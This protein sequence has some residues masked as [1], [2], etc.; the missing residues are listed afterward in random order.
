MERHSL[1]RE[2]DPAVRCWQGPAGGGSNGVLSVVGHTPLVPL[3]RLAAEAE[4]RV[5]GKLESL[6][7]GGSI[8][9]RPAAAIIAQGIR[10]GTITADT[11]VVESS[12]GNMGIG[13]AQACR[14]HG[15]RFI[16]VVDVKAMPQNIR[17]LQAYG[18]EIELVAAPD[19]ATGDFLT[20]R[21]GRVQE[22]L[23]RI[24]GAY[25]PNQYAN[26]ENPRSHFRSTMQ[27][28]LSEL[29]GDLD[30]LFVATSTCGTLRGCASF[31]HDHQLPTRLIA[32]DALGSLI[33]SDQ[34][35]H[36]WI[37][38]LGAGMKPPFGDPNLAAEVIHVTDGECVAGCRLLMEREAILAGGSSGGVVA[39]FHRVAPRI[40][41]RATS[42]LVLCDRGERYLD[43]VFDDDWVREHCGTI[44][45]ING[46]Q[47][48]P[49]VPRAAQS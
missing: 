12:S 9:D 7:P 11:V 15:L 35:G 37:P 17:I 46:S 10:S 5:Y 27:E 44:P 36:R 29:G 20:A 2:R 45:V 1:R 24:P 16:C 23:G 28:L 3:E 39:A 19:A 40:P 42:V 30:Y 22:L 48:W 8:K 38:G 25:W 18:A 33:F 13:L 31:I 34:V 41:P 43:T 6:N 21:L 4:L 49:S 26:E 32:V 47:E 14:Y